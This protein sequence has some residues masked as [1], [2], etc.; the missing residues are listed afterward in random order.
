M[1]GMVQNAVTNLLNLQAIAVGDISIRPDAALCAPETLWI[2]NVN[3]AV[4]VTAEGAWLTLLGPG[5][6]GGSVTADNG[7]SVFPGPG[8]IQLGDSALNRDTAIDTD[9]YLFTLGAAFAQFLV[10][11]GKVSMGDPQLSNNGTAVTVE[12][13]I[14]R[15]AIENYAAGIETSGVNEVI[16]IGDINNESGGMQLVIL[17]SISQILSIIQGAGSGI[18]IENGGGGKPLVT[19]GDFNNTYNATKLTVDDVAQ[20]IVL[21]SALGVVSIKNLP[22]YAD[23]KDAL[24]NGLTAGRLYLIVSGVIPAGAA[25]PLGV[26]Y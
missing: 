8:N 13:Q 24:A 3:N 23:N 26:V 20:S 19:F 6:G 5:G 11:V 4:Y 21:D 12:D 17:N 2:D 16:N 22:E 10:N 7:L 18:R 9:A 14:R 15:V 25:K 1:E